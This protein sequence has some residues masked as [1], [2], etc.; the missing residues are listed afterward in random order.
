MA[1]TS[2]HA[3]TRTARAARGV[4]GRPARRAALRRR[5]R[6]AR[7]APGPLRARRVRRARRRRRLRLADRRRARGRSDSR[8]VLL[9]AAFSTMTALL[10]IHGLAT[11]GIIVGPERR[12]RARR[13]RL[14]ARRRRRARAERAA[15]DAPPAADAPGARAAGGPRRRDPRARHD[16]PALPLRRAERPAGRQRRR[17]SCCS[18][19]APPFFALLALRA[20]RTY[21]LTR[22]TTDLLVSVGCVWLGWA[23]VPQLLMGYGTLGVLLR[24]RHGA[25][26]HRPDRASRPC[27]TC[28]RAGPR[29]RS[30]ATSPRRTSSA[31]RSRS[32]ARACAR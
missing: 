13:R 8:T 6:G 16:R 25:A 10:A 7:R 4:G 21:T 28:A 5:A 22:R 24:P 32:S 18:S 12:H 15:R 9:G 3:P 30:S 14:A 26:R 2:G 27:S 17:R 11:P 29:A 31:P 1:K 19:S 23:L 20:A